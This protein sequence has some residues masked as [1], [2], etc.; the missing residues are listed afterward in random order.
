MDYLTIQNIQNMH[1]L[2]PIY[3]KIKKTLKE[4]AKEYFTY[5]ENSR[6]YPNPP[7][8]TDL[9]I[10]SLALCSEATQ[11]TSENYL[12]AKLKTDYKTMFNELPHRTRYNYRK[13]AL[14]QLLMKCTDSLASHVIDPDDAL[15]IDSMPIP[16]C[17]VI[18]ERK[19]KACRRPEFD[20]I[21]ADK[22]FNKVM[23]GYFIGYKFHLITT[24]S[25]VYVDMLISKASTHDSFF[26]K[27][28]EQSDE[29]LRNKTLL[30]DRGYIGKATQLRLFEELK[31]NL[32]IPYRRN[33]KDF[34]EYAISKKIKRKSI[35]VVFSQ[36]CDEFSIK[37]NY[38]K[39]YDGLEIRLYY[40]IATKTF[41]QYWNMI[42]G[43][44]I[45]QTK[46]AF[47]A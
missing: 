10:I 27:L 37:H 43:K 14:S 19:S 30:G 34:K 24:E 38:A 44:P 28:L 36:L 46:H 40:K 16:T 11:I 35:E 33:Q 41:K 18:R 42:N 32:D 2:V 5:G 29:H 25:G 7:K 1:D 47:A 9:E 6:F 20:E 15:V 39:R 21:M 17:R 13:K 45:N 22:G 26:L 12:W 31:L 4:V 8:L 23:G 3:N